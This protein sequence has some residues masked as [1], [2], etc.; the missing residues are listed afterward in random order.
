MTAGLLMAGVGVALYAIF[1]ERQP[2]VLWR[3]YLLA[4][5]NCWPVVMGGM[6]LLALGNLTG[7]RWAA[8]ARPYYLA[9]AKTLPFLAILFIPIGFGL[10]HIYP[11]AYAGTENTHGF[12]PAKA[13]YLSPPFFLSRAAAYFII[14]LLVGRW[15]VSVSQ[16]DW[17]PASTPSMRRAGAVSLVLLVPTTTFAA[18]DWAMS[19]EP[20]W[21]SSIYGAILT[22][23][24][25][26]AAHALAVVTLALK[27]GVRYGGAFIAP[28]ER[29]NHTRHIPSDNFGDLGNLLL[30]FIMVWA[31]FMFS[32]FLIIWSA[33]L[34]S[35]ITWYERRLSGGWQFVAVAMVLICFAVPFF[36]LLLHDVKRNTRR[37]AIVA[38]LLL[39]GYALN[40]FWT[41]APA[42]PSAGRAEYVASAGA[43]MGTPGLW[44]ALYCWQAGRMEH[45]VR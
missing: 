35:E 3:A 30:A 28:L 11:W 25:V 36:A 2:A 22:A 38:T 5:L 24:G 4:F 16:L 14:W 23:G 34:P 1:Y 19:L 40:M 12:S 8:A 6:G 26:V 31:Y 13:M 10:D 32:Q 43:V 45:H 37:L 39:V 15:L 20:H 7:G 42:F 17:P 33:N 29:D 41:I 27:S 18:F 9:I 44:F 21:Y